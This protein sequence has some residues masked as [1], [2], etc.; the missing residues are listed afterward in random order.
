MPTL[1]LVRHAKSSRDDAG[2]DDHDRPLAA[3]GR[4]AA[5][6]MA[7]WMAENGIS[8]ELVLVSTARRCRE[9]WSAMQSAFQARPEMLF[10]AGLYLASADELLERLRRVAGDCPEVMLI[11][12][13]PGLHDLSVGLAGQ[14][15][16]A[17]SG[18]VEKFPTVALCSLAVAGKSW[19]RL[20]P[21]GARLI[22]FL[23]PADIA[24]E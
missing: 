20:G 16:A 18:L 10:E 5:T 23:R 14:G 2:L 21:G 13:N 17:A 24:A 7:R 4:K 3:R 9:T 1:H 19:A 12:H 6:A 11:G 22:R 15:G 8:P